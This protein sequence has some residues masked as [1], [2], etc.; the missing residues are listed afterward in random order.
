MCK[1]WFLTAEMIELI[2]S[3][4]DNIICM[5]PFA[6]LPNQVTGKSMI[7]ALKDR[8]PQ[9]NIVAIDFDPGASEV[10][11]LTRIKLL[12]SVAFKKIEEQETA[13]AKPTRQE[14]FRA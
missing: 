1:D 13:E 4:T 11:Q 8:H 6:G 14:R 10:N 5:Q 3:G 9:A 12:L 2:E 7:K